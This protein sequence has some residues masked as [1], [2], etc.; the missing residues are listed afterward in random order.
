MEHKCEDCKFAKTKHLN[1]H[2]CLNCSVRPTWYNF[3]PAESKVLT[4]EEIAE[5]IVFNNGTPFRAD[6]IKYGNTMHQNGKLERDLEVRP[7]IEA[8]KEFFSEDNSLGC[9]DILYELE[10][11]KPLNGDD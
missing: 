8:V 5:K 3:I 4:A 1:E 7:M 9:D 11:L 10:N 2:P 6:V